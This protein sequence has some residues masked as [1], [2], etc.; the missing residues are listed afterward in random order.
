MK[1]YDIALD[2][3]DWEDGSWQ[4][5][6]LEQFFCEEDKVQYTLHNAEEIH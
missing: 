5:F 3:A 6:A 1:N 4:E 2:Y